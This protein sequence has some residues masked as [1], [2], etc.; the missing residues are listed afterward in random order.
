MAKDTR[1]FIRISSA[2]KDRIKSA[3]Q[4]TDTDMS[5]LMRDAVMSWVALIEKGETK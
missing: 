3:S 1:V 5:T 4:V 2:E